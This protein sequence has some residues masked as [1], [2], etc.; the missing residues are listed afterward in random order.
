[1]RTILFA[2]LVGAMVVVL[3]NDSQAQ[4]QGGFKFPNLNPFAKKDTNELWDSPSAPKKPFQGFKFPTLP[5]FGKS[6]KSGPSPL[7]KL[8]TRTQKFVKNTKE[9]LMPWTKKKPSPI[10][11]S[12]LRTA[13]N[14][15]K[16]FLKGLFKPVSFNQDADKPMSTANDWLKQPRP[17][18][19]GN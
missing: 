18:W 16:G 1:M 10:T 3:T 9:T 17:R 12:N 19:G 13:K 11:G 2:M 8:N 4:E 5:S 14:Q 15:K 6:K 7:Q